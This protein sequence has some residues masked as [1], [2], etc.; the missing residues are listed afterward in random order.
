MHVGRA[1]CRRR[2]RGSRST[3]EPGLRP[4]RRNFL[5]GLPGR[6]RRRSRRLN[7]RAR[8]AA[9]DRGG[10]GAIQAQC[11]FSRCQGTPARPRP[12]TTAIAGGTSPR[13]ARLESARGRG[14]AAS[15]AR[16][17][18]IRRG[19]GQ[20]RAD[21]RPR[22]AVRRSPG[23][24][25]LTEETTPERHRRR[26]VGHRRRGSQVPPAA[27]LAV[28]RRRRS[29]GRPGPP[30]PTRSA[31]PPVVPGST[32]RLI[33]PFVHCAF[34]ARARSLRSLHRG[35]R[36]INVLVDLPWGPQMKLSGG[37]GSR[38]SHCGWFAPKILALGRQRPE[39]GPRGLPSVASAIPRRV[40]R[41]SRSKH[42]SGVYATL[43]R[44]LR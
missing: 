12:A 34:G 13:V 4:G 30:R 24:P 26:G 14:P 10:R 15:A 3:V 9:A 8:R 39:V 43:R 18:E 31:G 23:N 6:D 16:R 7:R 25:A 22:A 5:F 17:A 36:F 40:R 38:N 19:G 37:T 29:T 11:R 1:A 35:R 20:L 28:A 21:T 41:P 33:G 44:G 2:A 42:A 32:P 27:G